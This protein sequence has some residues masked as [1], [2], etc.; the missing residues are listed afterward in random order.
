MSVDS[1]NEGEQPNSFFG[2]IDALLSTGTEQIQNFRFID[3]EDNLEKAFLMAIKSKYKV[4]IAYSKYS[5][6]LFLS[7]RTTKKFSDFISEFKKTELFKEFNDSIG[8]ALLDDVEN[9]YFR[10]SQYLQPYFYIKMNPF[11]FILQK[12]ENEANIEL[13][14]LTIYLRLLKTCK[15]SFKKNSIAT[16]LSSSIFN[17]FVNYYLNKIKNHK[18]K[19]RTIDESKFKEFVQIERIFLKGANLKLL[20]KFENDVL[21]DFLSSDFLNKQ[22]YALIRLNRN[23]I[24]NKELIEQLNHRKIID[25]LF[26]TL[27]H[28]LIVQFS[29][30]L[31][32]MFSYGQYEDR[33][34]EQLWELTFQQSDYIKDYF[35]VWPTI[36]NS[37]SQKSQ[38][39]V[40]NLILNQ[41][42]YFTEPVLL[43]LK[44]VSYKCVDKKPVLDIL[45]NAAIRSHDGENFI[46]CIYMYTPKDSENRRQLKIR[47]FDLLK[48]PDE[49]MT[50]NYDNTLFALKLLMKIWKHFDSKSTREELDIL[51][52]NVK[53]S[54]V[55]A[56]T[57]FELIS[58]IS[59]FLDSPFS[60]EE[61]NLLEDQILKV[62]KDNSQPVFD[63]FICLLKNSK[64]KLFTQETLLLLIK[65]FS[66]LQNINEITFKLIKHIY[67]RINFQNKVS[68]L[69]NI[70]NL[71]FRTEIPDVACYLVKLYGEQNSNIKE[72]IDNCLRKIDCFGAL[73]ALKMLIIEIEEPLDPENYN[74]K[75]NIYTGYKDILT[76]NLSKDYIGKVKI[77]KDTSYQT[78]RAIIKRLTKAKDSEI[79]L[80]SLQE[81]LN[82]SYHFRDN[83]TIKVFI[84]KDSDSTE[85]KR[86][87]KSD[88][89]SFI[90]LNHREH[91]KSLIK[92]GNN[93]RDLH[94]CEAALDLL[95][96]LPI[97]EE[98]IT[99]LKTKSDLFDISQPFLF[100][101]R[102]NLLANLIN[103]DDFEVL[104]NLYQSNLYSQ[105]MLTLFEIPQNIFSKDEYFDLFL[106]TIVEINRRGRE[107]EF[108]KFQKKI[109]KKIANHDT[110]LSLI[111]NILE[112]EKKLI[113]NDDRII[114]FLQLLVF[115]TQNDKKIL[116]TH[117]KFP[118]LFDSLIFNEN[119]NIRINFFNLLTHINLKKISSFILSR[120]QLSKDG[121]C[122]EFFELVK[123]M[124]RSSKKKQYIFDALIDSFNGNLLI[125]KNVTIQSKDQYLIEAVNDL[126]STVADQEYIT[127]IIENIYELFSNIEISNPE[128]LLHLLVDKIVFNVNRYVFTP[129]ILFPLLKRILDRH[130]S[131]FLPL[132]KS[133]TKINQSLPE[134]QSS[135]SFLSSEQHDKGINNL[136]CTCYLNSSLQQLFRI[137]PIRDAIFAYDPQKVGET[138]KLNKINT[139]SI[140]EDWLCQLQLMFAHLKYSPLAS[141]DA[142]N[143]VKNWRMYGDEPIDPNEQQDAVEFITI[144]LDRLDEILPGKPISKAIRGQIIHTTKQINGDYESIAHESFITFALEVKK[145]TCFGESF[146]VFLEPDIFDGT[147]QYRA[148]EIGLIDA[149][150]SHAI[151][152]AP[153]FMIFQLKRFDFDLSTLKK[154]KINTQFK[155]EKIVDIS[156]VFENQQLVD[157]VLYELCGIIQHSGNADGGHYY[158]YIKENEQWKE[159]ND[160]TVKLVDEEIVLSKATGGSESKR[161]YDP[162]SRMTKQSTVMRSESAY[163]LFYKLKKGNLYEKHNKIEN[164][165]NNETTEIKELDEPIVLMPEKMLREFFHQMKLIILKNVLFTTDYIDLIDYISNSDSYDTF[166]FLFQFTIRAIGSSSNKY[167]SSSIIQTTL[168]KAKSNRE[169]AMFI[170]KN[171]E[172]LVE[173]LFNYTDEKQLSIC[174]NIANTALA[175]V[176]KEGKILIDAITEKEEEIINHWSNIY[177]IL[178]PVF[179]YFVYIE[180][181]KDISEAGNHNNNDKINSEKYLSFLLRLLK[182]VMSGEIK[183]NPK[184]VNMSLVFRIIKYIL[185]NHNDDESYYNLVKK[186][187]FNIEFLKYY[188]QSDKHTFD[189]TALVV[190]FIK[191]NKEITNKYLNIIESET[192]MPPNIL[193]SHFANFIALKD[194]LTSYRVNWILTHI[195]NLEWDNND[196]ELFFK[197]AATNLKQNRGASTNNKNIG[198]NLTQFEIDFKNDFAIGENNEDFDPTPLFE[199]ES[200]SW[201]KQWLIIDDESIR[202]SCASFI[203]SL[204]PSFP[205]FKSGFI[206]IKPNLENRDDI[207]H[208]G[209]EHEKVCIRKL[210]N[211]LINLQKDLITVSKNVA[212]N[213]DDYNSELDLP[214]NTYFELLTWASFY[215][216]DSNLKSYSNNFSKLVTTLSSLKNGVR[217]GVIDLIQFISYSYPSLINSSNVSIYLTAISKFPSNSDFSSHLINVSIYL[218]PIII[219]IASKIDQQLLKSKFIKLCFKK[220]FNE[221]CNQSKQLI[222]LIKNMKK[223]EILC[224]LVW[225]KRTTW[226]SCSSLL[227]VTTELLTDGWHSA[228]LFRDMNCHTSIINT[229]VTQY[230]GSTVSYKK[231]ETMLSILHD[232]NQIL[233]EMNHNDKKFGRE[234]KKS[235]LD[236]WKQPSNSKLFKILYKSL[237]DSPDDFTG[238]CLLVLNDVFNSKSKEFQIF[239]NDINCKEKSKDITMQIYKNIKGTFLLSFA[240]LRIS[241]IHIQSNN[242]DEKESFLIN[243]IK[244]VHKC[245]IFRHEILSMFLEIIPNKNSRSLILSEFFTNVLDLDQYNFQFLKENK[246][247]IQKNWVSHLSHLIQEEMNE[248]TQFT[249]KDY[250]VALVPKLIN[251]EKCLLLMLNKLNKSQITMNQETIK[252]C[253]NIVKGKEEKEL[254]EFRDIA[255]KLLVLCK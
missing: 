208:S 232:Y 219:P 135:G 174:C 39:L 206:T 113:T 35:S 32:K 34:I 178:N 175:T 2:E 59:S 228:K 86:L 76:I 222:D 48:T 238:K 160:S 148:D 3:A 97:D 43:F 52:N 182:N 220:F 195:S 60:E 136:G 213:I 6:S 75:R 42:P 249:K 169:F 157:P 231:W 10:V 107:S 201:L 164:F 133:L 128:L 154:K 67:K 4:G 204:F 47:C 56:S 167:N 65:W 13:S 45:W 78:F 177:Y 64:S 166:P 66:N 108:K 37:I 46:D 183:V 105:L 103:D 210:F 94:I 143:F 72:F 83:E 144:L 9:F 57:F 172:M 170:V 73:S 184:K 189:F 15:D 188:S 129:S 95:N 7:H 190:Y 163:I 116:I 176:G 251:A 226:G 14:K 225:K 147:N 171:H 235:F 150:R 41:T 80:M 21:L 92:I 141:I 87:E 191:E 44:K 236:L 241:I 131:L 132:V 181:K 218:F 33:Y 91:L 142:N 25:K 63:F 137:Q 50:E 207:I 192:D 93:K 197:T 239:L 28:D 36:M 12:V 126:C 153:K 168:T 120:L 214:T 250:F 212:A 173:S 254:N 233:F 252:N 134:L 211:I 242:N 119:K 5:L 74:I 109:L 139:D 84:S 115:F 127:G 151:S 185:M 145:K 146:D 199:K 247:F 53:I 255:N 158:S 81:E 202:S 54:P 186:E 101:Y 149:S 18:K 1:P 88:L 193:A 24:F 180:A 196:I 162:V 140:D 17:N 79:T 77:P 71:L 124:C 27:H 240:K 227:T 16:D 161:F 8:T 38:K 102:I 122:Y 230:E 223:S 215:Y 221:N 51:L 55:N 243:E 29:T 244:C 106:D 111:N 194:S 11:P 58:N 117:T 110:I 31:A 125:T 19:L 152:K 229:F 237:I 155:V 138:S 209:S 156:K 253:L 99:N 179:Y 89:P 159:I 224:K 216:Y 85:P 198:K 234:Y 100:I 82:N 49:K 98:E 114:D 205:K 123:R 69:E 248:I 165:N 96:Y 121:R 203:Y 20:D 26:A 200:P 245:M 30:F 40:W 246:E 187:I 68:S 112:E 61:I 118:E 217:H 22:F 23:K 130:K 70:W 104:Q 90:L 62:I